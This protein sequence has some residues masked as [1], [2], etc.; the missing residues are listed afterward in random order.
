MSVELYVVPGSNASLT[1]RLM[2]D[3]KGIAYE[4]KDLV[5][6]AHVPLLKAR[7]FPGITV[8]ALRLDGRKIQG[9]RDI[10]RAL[11]EL[12]PEPPLLPADPARRRAV[13]EAEALGEGPLQH[14]ARRLLYGA[15]RRDPSSFTSVILG[16]ESGLGPVAR[17]IVR[18]GARG[19][20]WA[21][22]QGHGAT[23]EACREAIAALPDMLDRVDRWI[24][25]GVLN[26]EELNAADFQV[27]A[28]VRLLLLFDD[29]APA[30]EGRPAAELA[31]RVAP[32]YPGRIRAVFPREWL[33]PIRSAWGGG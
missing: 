32:Q 28:N 13:E 27:G 6:G 1:G 33:G 26:G 16:Q 23:D 24:E 9:T 11:D 21:A 2:L 4:R 12:R 8:P 3:H 17:A 7:G 10:A 22:T 30:I 18:A 29:L 31:V 14:A 5:P 25:E 20:V 19:I 15:A